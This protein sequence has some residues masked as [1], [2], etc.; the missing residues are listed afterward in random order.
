MI[1]IELLLVDDPSM[2]NNT[3]ILKS[4][5]QYVLFWPMIYSAN[6]CSINDHCH[7]SNRND[8]CVAESKFEDDVIVDLWG[9]IVDRKV[10]GGVYLN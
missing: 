8:N 7:A 3:P 6:K 4:L 10:V 1:P 5:L 9:P 2:D